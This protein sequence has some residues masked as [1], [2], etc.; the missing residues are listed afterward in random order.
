MPNDGCRRDDAESGWVVWGRRCAWVAVWGISLA[1]GGGSGQPALPDTGVTGAP[2]EAGRPIAGL[3]V[4]RRVSEVWKRF[5][6]LP[7][8]EDGLS[9][10]CYY[11]ARC[12]MYGKERRFMRVHLMNR[13][14]LDERR[15]IKADDTT[16]YKVPVF[17][18]VISEEVPTENYNYR[19]L[20]VV[21][22]ER[23]SLEP[24]EVT[25]SSQEWCGTSFKQLQWSRFQEVAPEGWSL[26]M[27]S[28]SY[29]PGEGDVWKP[30]PAG[31]DAYEGLFLF[32][33]AVAASGCESRPMRLLPT[34]RTNRG[35]D[36]HPVDAVLRCEGGP[37]EI[38]IPLGKVRAQR[39]VVDWEGAETWFDVGTDAPHVLAAFRAGDVQAELRFTERR[40][41]WDRA[42]TSGFHKPGEAP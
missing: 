7:L 24:L 14:F 6:A 33:R 40:A 2:E 13:Q 37:R 20:T 11:D 19:Y 41:Y 34:L 26:D 25:V 3:E 32:A 18:L 22:Q 15:W 30:L 38:S 29:F 16:T 4:P 35:A 5:S 28:F 17:K 21:F 8:W 31:V 42:W 9:E 1:S 12:E 10:M 23:P 36:A 27:L 39:V